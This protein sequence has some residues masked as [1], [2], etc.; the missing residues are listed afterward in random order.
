MHSIDSRSSFSAKE[1][2]L[3]ILEIAEFLEGPF[4][5]PRIR[6]ECFKARFNVLEMYSMDSDVLLAMEILHIVD[7]LGF[8]AAEITRFYE[9]NKR[10]RRYLCPN[11]RENSMDFQANLAQLRPNTPVST[12]VYCIS[13][14][15]NYAVIRQPCS[16]ENCRGN[17]IEEVDGQCLTCGELNNIEL[18]DGD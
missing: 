5:W 7:D 11:C 15:E 6:S 17:V 1:V 3:S 14:R 18:N 13:C 10:Q 12:N 2:A 9:F 16:E 8:Q 4:S